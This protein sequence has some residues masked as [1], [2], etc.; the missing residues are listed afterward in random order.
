M[1]NHPVAGDIVEDPL[2]R[3]RGTAAVVLLWEP[4]N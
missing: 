3:R 2:V 1:H 4:V